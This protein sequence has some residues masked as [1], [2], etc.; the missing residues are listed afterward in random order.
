M[1]VFQIFSNA[2]EYIY[3]LTLGMLLLSVYWYFISRRRRVLAAFFSDGKPIR[4]YKLDNTAAAKGFADIRFPNY[5]TKPARAYLCTDVSGGEPQ[6]WTFR[7]KGG[8]SAINIEDGQPYELYGRSYIFRSYLGTH[9]PYR[10]HFISI[11]LLVVF[12]LVIQM[13]FSVY[14]SFEYIK[15][16]QMYDMQLASSLRLPDELNYWIIPFF[17]LFLL[18]AVIL[19]FIGIDHSRRITPDIILSFFLSFM[20]FVLFPGRGTFICIV[21]GWCIWCFASPF[22]SKLLMYVSSLWNRRKVVP[23]VLAAGVLCVLFLAGSGLFK[24]PFW[25]Q[26]YTEK[27]RPAQVQR[28]RVFSAAGGQKGFGLYKGHFRAE[29]PHSQSDFIVGVLFEEIGLRT[30]MLCIA[31]TMLVA[32]GCYFQGVR[33]EKFIP[34]ILCFLIAI[35]TGL[36][37]IINLASA[38]GIPANIMGFRLYLPMP[39]LSHSMEASIVLFICLSLVEAVKLSWV[40]KKPVHRGNT[41][42]EYSKIEPGVI[43][44]QTSKAGIDAPEEGIDAPE[45]GINAPEEGI[46][47][48]EEGI[49]EIGYIEN[50][51]EIITDQ[52][53]GEPEAVPHEEDELISVG[54]PESEV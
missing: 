46:D 13:Y 45:E 37:I 28:L 40:N 42:G 52:G 17:G 33:S 43:P 3:Y 30:G 8:G 31:L 22:L 34:A 12:S 48:P 24:G 35:F 15:I 25:E 44:D 7:T 38:T 49:I 18:E 5:E 2:E 21:A 41:R 16:D 26:N 20:G 51:P 11:L 27:D 39:F 23:I 4:V 53:P 1:A 6:G 50:D 9:K 54:E 29:N 10:G 32:Y 36:R 19:G 47:A 14:A